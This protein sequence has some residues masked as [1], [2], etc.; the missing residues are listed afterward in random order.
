M[1][2]W[3]IAD[4]W[5]DIGVQNLFCRDI[6]VQNLFCRDIGVQNLFCRDIGVQNLFCRDIGVQNLFCNKPFYGNAPIKKG[7]SRN[8]KTLSTEA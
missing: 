8:R 7:I 6:G 4:S 2:E 3:L 1:V 5:R